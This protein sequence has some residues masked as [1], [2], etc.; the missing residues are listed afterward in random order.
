[1]V[2]QPDIVFGDKELEAECVHFSSTNDQQNR[3]S[4]SPARL[5]G[6]VLVF[7]QMHVGASVWSI[8]IR[9]STQCTEPAFYGTGIRPVL[10]LRS[11]VKPSSNGLDGLEWTD[12]R[13]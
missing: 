6:Q 10:L 7:M 13:R 11:Q 12:R 4:S 9:E 5:G 1:M 8:R 3:F 2:G